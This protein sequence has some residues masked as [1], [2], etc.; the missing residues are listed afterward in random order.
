MAKKKMRA[1]IKSYEKWYVDQFAER[2]NKL[3]IA[4]IIKPLG[5]RWFLYC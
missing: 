1:I 5:R 4:T 2:L 3:G